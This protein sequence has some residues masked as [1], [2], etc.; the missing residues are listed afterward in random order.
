MS[1]TTQQ[2][3]AHL[4]AILDALDRAANRQRVTVQMILKELGERSFAPLLLV[5]ALLLVS[6]LSGIPGVPTVGS[7][8]M[9]LIVVQSLVGRQHIWLP[10]MLMRRHVSGKRLLRSV[11][12]IRKPAAWVDRHTRRRLSWLTRWPLKLIPL[13]I[14]LAICAVLPL[15]EL[16]PFVTST[17][18]FAITLFAIGILTRDGLFVLA[19]FAFTGSLAGLAVYLV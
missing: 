15:L 2:P 12:W 16:L 4:S 19:G 14:A 7:I 8:V 5:P 6:P 13:L 9:G 10:D 1:E 18:A 17:G 11:S 3:P